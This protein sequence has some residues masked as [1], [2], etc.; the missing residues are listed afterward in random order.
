MATIFFLPRVITFFH[1]RDKDLCST[2]SMPLKNVLLG[3]I[4][5]VKV[6]N[7]VLKVVSV[8]ACL[9]NCNLFKSTIISNYCRM[10]LRLNYSF[11]KFYFYAFLLQYKVKLK[12][13]SNKGQPSS[14]TQNTK[15]KKKMS[16]N[17][18][19]KLIKNTSLKTHSRITGNPGIPRSLGS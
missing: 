18:R 1:T 14:G 7:W 13:Y 3:A 17:K 19:L 6:A 2:L 16:R 12:F 9:I 11:K 15:W 4:I 10:H 8:F 5:S